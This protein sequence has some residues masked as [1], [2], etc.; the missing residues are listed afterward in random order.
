VLAG[1]EV[2]LKN[3]L[4][5]YG[6][7]FWPWLLSRTGL[8]HRLTASRRADCERTKGFFFRTPQERTIADFKAIRPAVEFGAIRPRSLDLHDFF[9]SL[10]LLP[11]ICHLLVV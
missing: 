10:R 1:Q 11:I 4:M 9:I 6:S 3:D 5:E 8:Y 2:F 7:I